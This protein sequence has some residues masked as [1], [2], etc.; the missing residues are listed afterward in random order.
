MGKIIFAHTEIAGHSHEDPLAGG[1]ELAQGV[2]QQE[3]GASNGG[4]NH[5]QWPSAAAQQ[6][7]EER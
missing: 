1:G 3:L 7:R 2:R 4:A 5:S 6:E